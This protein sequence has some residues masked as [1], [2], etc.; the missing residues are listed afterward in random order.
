MKQTCSEKTGSPSKQLALFVKP[1]WPWVVLDI[2]AALASAVVDVAGGYFIQAITD[3]TLNNQ[4]ELVRGTVALILIT[5]MIGIIAKFAVKYTSGRFSAQSLRDLRQNTTARVARM[6]FSDVEAKHSGDTV[7]RL[8]NDIAIVQAFLQNSF[9]EFIY[10]PIAFLAAFVYMATLDWSLLLVAMAVVPLTIWLTNVFSR[11]LSR[12]IK[13][14]QEGFSKINALAEDS[15]GGIYVAKAFNLQDALSQRF[16]GAVDMARDG[17]HK[18]QWRLAAMTPL[19][20]IISTIPVLFTAVYGG[21]LALDGRMTPGGLFAFMYLLHF[22]VEPLTAMTDLISELRTVTGTAGRI[23]QVLHQPIERTNGQ[24]FQADSRQPII[25]FENVSFAY[26]EQIGVLDET[27]FSIPC[28]KTVALVG[29]SGSGKS[30]VFKLLCGFYEPR[31]GKIKLY[32]QELGTW[33]LECA[34][35]QLALVAQDTFLFPATIAENISF[36]NPGASMD[37]LIDAAKAAN[38]HDFIV[39]LPNGYETI[40]GERGNRLSGGE[41]QRI[42]IARAILKNAPVLLLDEPTSALD[43]H[44]EAIVQQALERFAGGRTVLV[45]AHRMSTIKLADEILVLDHGRIVEKGTH[46]ELVARDGLYKQLYL[47]QFSADNARRS[48]I[49]IRTE[50]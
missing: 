46:A 45:I 2:I 7:S 20:T 21:W 23:V 6:R 19:P 50:A 18:R 33:A 37:R 16:Q 15:I 49:M 28:S 27:S 8:T 32:G 29:P 1:Y 41:R 24:S 13:E 39:A 38:A 35:Q 10:Q 4:L 43:T 31:H 26:S 17:E 48:Q 44:S 12:Y 40:V 5:V 47:Q 11:P 42:G 30:T 14:R 3:A 9:S 34:R 36:G 22:L 25:E